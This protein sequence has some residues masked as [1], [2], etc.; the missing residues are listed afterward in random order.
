MPKFDS[1]LSVFCKDSTAVNNAGQ[2]GLE[3]YKV[4]VRE[5]P[6]NTERKATPRAKTRFFYAI[7]H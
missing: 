6:F 5:I 7:R 1:D 2:S 4:G 3:A